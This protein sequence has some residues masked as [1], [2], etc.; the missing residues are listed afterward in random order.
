MLDC[1]Q[2]PVDGNCSAGRFVRFGLFKFCDD[3]C[4]SSLERLDFLFESLD[5]LVLSLAL[6]RS[7]LA[8]FGF[9]AF[10]VFSRNR[11]VSVHGGSRSL[12]WTVPALRRSLSG[13]SGGQAGAFRLRFRFVEVILVAARIMS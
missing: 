7:S 4:L 12:L 3:L 6:A 13:H 10:L 1:K 8:V 5:D 11:D 2:F 9:Q